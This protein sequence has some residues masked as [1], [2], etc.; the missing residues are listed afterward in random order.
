[1]DEIEL[2]LVN[3]QVLRIID[4]EFEIW[5]DPRFISNVGGVYNIETHIHCRLRRAQINA[6][7]FTLRMLVGWEKVS[8]LQSFLRKD[9]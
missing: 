2:L 3:P 8:S 5:W 9:R 7:H 4:Y 1:M 6:K